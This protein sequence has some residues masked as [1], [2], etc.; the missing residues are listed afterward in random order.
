MKILLIS[1]MYPSKDYPFYG[2]FVKNFEN[3]LIAEGFEFEKAVIKGRGRTKLEKLKK[4]FQFFA[5]VF[6]ALREDK[7]DLIY[8]HYAEH[9]LI[10]LTLFG[11]LIKKPLI[12]N[13]HGDDISYPSFISS[14]VKSTIKKCDLI[15]VPSNYFKEIVGQN[16]NH[17]NVFVSPS[18]GI[19][20]NLFKPIVVERSKLFTIGF[21]SRIDEGKGWDILLDAVY[22]LKQKNLNFKVLLVG[23]GD[24]KDAMLKKIDELE[25]SSIVEYVGAKP[26]DELPHCFNQMDI[27]TFPTI[28]KAE[29][30]GL[31]G[32]E[33]M[34][35]GVPVVGSN[36]GGLP[37]Y[38]SDGVNGKLFEAGNS[39]ELVKCIE[40]FMTMDKDEFAKYKLQALE[41]AKRYDSKVVASELAEKLKELS[42]GNKEEK[43]TCVE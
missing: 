33:A 3:Q 21:V 38:I 41:T 30:L 7:Y 27:F 24:Q 36:I 19:D 14:F 1:N 11:H 26:H 39:E 35:C 29:S 16:Y 40:F 6:K 10:P 32:L 15:V 42:K 43:I 8:V 18:G 4:Y 17:N 34:A 28:R 9:S 20:T 2:I 37:S 12:I 23:S 13:A 22:L 31:V 5:D 25:L